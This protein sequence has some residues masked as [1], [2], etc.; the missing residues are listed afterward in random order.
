MLFTQKS[1]SCNYLKIY[2]WQGLSI[3][4][5]FLSMILVT[6]FLSSNQ[7]VF[8]IYSV[9]ISVSIFLVYSDLGFLGAGQKYAAEEYARGNLEMERRIVGFSGFVL[10]L[11]VVICSLIFTLFSIL[12]NILIP[13]ISELNGKIA[14]KLLLILAVFA[15]VTV[16]QRITQMIY[17]IRVEN[18]IY[19]RIMICGNIA[20]IASV[21]FF[22]R[23]GNYDIVGYFLFV[24]VVNLI[25]GLIALF[26]VSRRYSYRITKLIRAFHFDKKIFGKT[27]NL[28]FSGLFLVIFLGV[29]L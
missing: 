23:N 29:V 22:F 16:L 7:S 15:P 27:K 17:N 24:Q 8:G 6:P 19:Q 5:G 20:K 21:F 28:A 13:D 26:L 14:S 18:F 2:F 9:C 11:F 3:I 1:F 10:L 12:P 25:V 4:L